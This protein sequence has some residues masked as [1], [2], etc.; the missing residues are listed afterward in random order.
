MHKPM[1]AGAGGVLIASQAAPDLSS[2]YARVGRELAIQLSYHRPVHLV[3]VHGNVASSYTM[4]EGDQLVPVWPYPWAFFEPQHIVKLAQDINA[5]LVIFVGD[6]WP[7]ARKLYEAA[8]Q[9]PWVLMSPIDHAPLVA[10]EQVLSQQVAAWAC[11]TRWGT[12]AIRAADGNGIYVQHG[13]SQA[14]REAGAELGSRQAACDALGWDADV[15]RFVS[16][17]GNV[18][19][20]KNL[21]GLLRAWGDAGLQNAELVLWCYP[22]RDDSNPDGLD[23]LG[24]AREL[25]IK[26]VRFP[27][28]Y[29]LAVGYPDSDLAAV[30]MASDALVAPAKT[31]GFGIPIAEAQALGTPAIVTRYAPFLEVAGA[32]SSDPLTI[33]VGT[34]E[35]M[36]LLGTAWMP[37]PSHAGIVAALRHF[38]QHGIDQGDLERRI[39]HAQGYSWAT[40]AGDLNAEI[41]RILPVESSNSVPKTPA[42]VA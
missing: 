10:T 30:Y 23:L 35:L 15:L 26:N 37:T 29:Q 39:K 27:E 41:A 5:E 40:A 9:M 21:A 8:Q 18:G 6:A 34:W 25:G 13:V 7:F 12:D 24:A 1:T 36:Q 33:P 22:T 28:P 38:D 17:G 14:L 31:E 11:P 4:K 32:G 20:R 42:G 3:G 2:A 19:D 16:V